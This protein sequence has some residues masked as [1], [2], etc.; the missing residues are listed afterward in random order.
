LAGISDASVMSAPS[1][2]GVRVAYEQAP[3]ELHAWVEAT[4]GAAVVTATT[5]PGGFSPGI[6]AR[7]VCANGSRA[8]C[9]AVSA[10]AYEHAASLHRREQ[11]VTAAIPAAAP[12]PR[13]L[14]SY[15]DGSWVALLLQDIEGRQPALPWGLQELTRVVD[16]LDE[17]SRSLTPSPVIDVPTLAEAEAEDFQNWRALCAG[18]ADRAALDPWALRHLEAL[19]LLEPSWVVASE[20]DTLLHLDLRGDNLLIADDRVWV[21]DWPAACTGKPWVDIATFASSV[22]MQGGPPPAALLASSAIGRSVPHDELTAW[23]CALAGYFVGKS[24]EPAPSGL[25]TVRAFQ[26]AQGVVALAWLKELTGWV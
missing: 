18:S 11:G 14:S 6:A 1:A 10:R 7:L 12:V 5:Q 24:L 25:P 16:A 15:D 17:L 26:A 9:K 21:V 2:A 22:R 4:L 8:F 23:L 13:L 20:G 3:E 19:A